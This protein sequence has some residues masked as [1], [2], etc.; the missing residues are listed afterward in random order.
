MSICR[1]PITSRRYHNVYFILY[2]LHAWFCFILF[3]VVRSCA[4]L[5]CFV[6]IED[7]TEMDILIKTE[8]GET[9]EFHIKT[10][11]EPLD[12]APETGKIIVLSCNIK[13][14]SRFQG[15]KSNFWIQ[16]GWGIVNDI[17]TARNL[18]ARILG[19][20]ERSANQNDRLRKALPFMRQSN[21]LL[22]YVTVYE[23]DFRINPDDETQVT[24]KIGNNE[25]NKI[26]IEIMFQLICKKIS[27]IHRLIGM[28]SW[29]FGYHWK[30]CG[31]SE[32]DSTR[33][34]C[35]CLCRCP[36][37]RTNLED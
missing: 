6:F 21:N 3:C 24:S 12:L 18:M 13:I 37:T 31:Y 20:I 4:V 9:N 30:S 7:T 34:D 29:C 26:E 17:N 27:S 28:V 36:S 32:G 1:T 5:F 25:N 10:E 22:K 33:Q 11:L 23:R 35:R 19:E 8:V 14:I 15:D 16:D 2:W